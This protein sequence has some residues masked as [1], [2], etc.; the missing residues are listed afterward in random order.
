MQR[1]KVEWVCDGCGTVSE[2]PKEFTYYK[3]QKA[4][5]KPVEVDLCAAKCAKPFEDL[6]PKARTRDNVLRLRHKNSGAPS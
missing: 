6:W 2:D 3:I 5:G 4:K 1:A